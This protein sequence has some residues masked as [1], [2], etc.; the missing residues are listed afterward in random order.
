MVSY[1]G[2][3]TVFYSSINARHT[4]KLFRN[5]ITFITA[6]D[7]TVIRQGFLPEVQLKFSIIHVRAITSALLKV[8]ASFYSE[9]MWDEKPW[10]FFHI[11]SDK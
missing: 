2:E 1:L 5:G 8:K 11:F 3:P 9:L 10:F 4:L 6:C 7:M